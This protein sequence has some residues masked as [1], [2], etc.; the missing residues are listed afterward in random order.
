MLLV[1]RERLL[2]K[3]SAFRQQLCPMV[4]VLI[5][6]YWFWCL[7]IISRTLWRILTELYMLVIGIK[8]TVAFEIQ[9]VQS[10]I[11]PPGGIVSSAI[12]ILLC[13]HYFENSSYTFYWY[14]ESGCFRNSGLSVNNC[15]VYLFYLFLLFCV[16]FI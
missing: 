13:A 2:S 10:T 6:P 16:G 9:R 1:W 5:P 8:K 3:S 11:V 15:F 4:G 12:L 7:L 14:D